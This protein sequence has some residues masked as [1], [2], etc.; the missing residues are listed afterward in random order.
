MKKHRE[1][2][3]YYLLFLI[4]VS[5]IPLR[6]F[7]NPGM[8]KSH[9][10]EIHIARFA[11]FYKSF[12][13]G[14]IF[15]RWGENLNNGYGHPTLM[16]LYPLPN[17]L[18]VPF[19][20]LGFSLTTSIKLVF[21]FGYILS[22]MFMYLLL[23]KFVS[24][25]PAL[26]GA[27]FYLY[28]PYRFVDLFVRG[29][30]PEH[31]FFMF[32]PLSVISIL[33]FYRKPTHINL[34]ISSFTLSLLILVHNASSFFFFPFLF[35]LILIMHLSKETKNR[36]KFI[37]LISTPFIF[38]MILTSF[39]SIPAVIEGR[40]TLRNLIINKEFTISHLLEVKKFILPTWGY[41]DPRF[42]GGLSTQI[43]L[44]NIMVFVMLLLLV[45]IKKIKINFVLIYLIITFML[46]LFLMTKYSRIIWESNNILYNIHF[47]WRL[48]VLIGFITP[49]L[50]A[51]LFAYLEKKLLVVIMYK[52]YL[53]SMIVFF[54]IISTFSY[55][56]PSGYFNKNDS[57]FFEEYKG[58][59]DNGESSPIW[60]T[61]TTLDN[62]KADVEIIA[63]E[64]IIS[65]FHKK[66][67]IHTYKISV[68]SDQARIVDY[69]LYF[70]GWTLTDNGVN[71]ISLVQYQDPG[72]R[73]LITFWLDKGV[74]NINLK[75][76]ETK[77]RKISNTF[78][79][80]G[81][82]LILILP[83]KVIYLFKHD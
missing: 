70:P 4:I 46:T 10:G 62:R 47:P 51:F 76:E 81:L 75:L 71:K 11:S 38:S 50:T 53:L 65:N 82:I 24:E 28:F 8:F 29:A 54:L 61:L 69:T 41:L 58:T 52:N 3:S 31:L 39:Y 68:N 59:G 60:S 5:L 79:I 49:F 33:N 20:L 1:N 43:G 34:V 21:A 35:L 72:Y 19:H 6:S 80:I 2:K 73:G 22:G 45:I 77:I 56:K 42:E 67:E 57:Y 7:V 44:I 30:Y 15:P 12:F 17:Y 16:F 37:I 9:D 23:K 14:N 13:E 36:I 74:H 48:L 64:G 55:H 66:S 83:K 26:L 18:T 27:L 63:G 40:Y 32:A 25:F 78:S